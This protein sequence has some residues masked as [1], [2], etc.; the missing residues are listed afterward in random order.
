MKLAWA[1][2]IHLDHASEAVDEA[3]C[4]DI[5][6]S[7]A[8]ALLI[9]GDIGEAS[10]LVR[11]L[12]FVSE[13]VRLPVYFVLGNHDY[14]GSDIATVR[15]RMRTLDS[16]WAKWLPHA[17]L[18]ELSEHTALVGHGGWGDARFGNFEAPALLSDYFVIQ[19]LRE[20]TGGGNALAVLNN[21]PALE[22]KLGEL[23]GD[24]AAT[25]LPFYRDALE[26]FD[27]VLV[28]THV[29]PF[30]EACWHEGRISD[31]AW[32][33]GFTCKAM[34]QMLIEGARDH[35]DREVTVLCGH[36]HGSGEARILKNLVA[37]TGEARYGA[38]GFRVLEVK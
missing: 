4:A 37:I 12:H 29:P 3:F 33:P 26:R 30:R 10:N 16:A 14:Y 11:W 25:L 22:R 35:P 20:S 7:G 32:L 34:G 1:T 18:V 36:T 5:A 13:R 6:D 2:D 15:A 19:D 17:E 23:G 31:D 9:G 24:A 21:L 28:L 38:P 27:E 8:E